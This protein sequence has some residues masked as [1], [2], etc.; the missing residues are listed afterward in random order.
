MN[1]Q[2]TSQSKPSR[3]KGKA[4]DKDKGNDKEKQSRML[5]TLK[6]EEVLLVYMLEEF[7]D[8]IK[9]RAE[10]GFRSGFFGAVEIL[11]HK[12]LPGTT[13]RATPNIES[14]VKNWKE[15]Y[16]LLADMQR[17]SGLSWNH[18]TNSVIVDLPDVWE[19]YVKFHP[20]ANGMNGRAFPMYLSWQ[21]IFEKDRATGG[22]AEDPAEIRDNDWEEEIDQVGHEE[23]VVGTNECYIPSR[24]SHHSHEQC[25]CHHSHEQCQCQCQFKRHCQ[26]P[27]EEGKEVVKGGGKTKGTN[28]AFGSYM[29]ESKDVMVKLVDAMGY[30]QKQSNK[31]IGVFANLENLELEVEDM[32]T[33]NAMILASEERVDEFY[34]VPIWYRKHWV[35]GMLL[36]GKLATKTT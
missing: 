2:Q 17:L 22:M 3:G 6:E 10:N 26:S 35:V 8:G 19:E 25:Q 31:R 28:E 20:K 16:G 14:K 21:I 5:W 30:E 24:Q 1:S 7:K 34:R 29:D 33:A 27:A 9:R 11:F 18:D 4:K 12:M 13:I 23:S 36:Q 32:L 15:K